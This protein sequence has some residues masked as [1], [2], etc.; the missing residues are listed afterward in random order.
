VNATIEQLHFIGKSTEV[1]KRVP[2]VF[3]NSP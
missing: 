2:C 3:L 1:L